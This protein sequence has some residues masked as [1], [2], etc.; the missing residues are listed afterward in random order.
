MKTFRRAVKL[1]E[2]PLFYIVTSNISR[3]KPK[4]WLPSLIHKLKR[5]DKEKDRWIV[6]GLKH[7]WMW[8]VDE[9]FNSSNGV[10]SLRTFFFCERTLKC[11]NIHQHDCGHLRKE[12]ETVTMSTDVSEFVNL[13]ESPT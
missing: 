7:W 4:V 2:L 10:L 9:T 6:N 12:E 8:S 1:K 13:I 5:S 11:W 3:E